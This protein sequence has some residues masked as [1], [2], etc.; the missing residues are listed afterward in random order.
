MA[1]NS[2]LGETRESNGEGVAVRNGVLTRCGLIVGGAF[3][4]D[5]YVDVG[6]ILAIGE[7]EFSRAVGNAVLGEQDANEMTTNNSTIRRLS[8]ITS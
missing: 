4:V 8:K 7:A 1:T 2:L 6:S 3:G 5:V